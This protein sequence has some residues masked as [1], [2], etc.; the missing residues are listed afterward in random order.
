M[1]GDVVMDGIAV[2]Q[3]EVAAKPEKPAGKRRIGLIVAIVVAIVAIGALRT[4][5]CGRAVSIRS[6][7]SWAHIS[8]HLDR[9]QAAAK[10]PGAKSQT[11]AQQPSKSSELAAVATP[12]W[13]AKHHVRGAADLA[14]GHHGDD[15]QRGRQLRLLRTGTTPRTAC[16]FPFKAT[17]TDG[18]TKNGTIS[19]L[20]VDGAWFFA[21]LD[22]GVTK[23]VPDTQSTSRSST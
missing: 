23:E 1:Q 18:T 19:L 11:P 5:S 20:S 14:G 21:G 2:P 10:A 8:A 3:V 6:P 13:A 16:R 17:L 4:R 7:R 15:R 9:A 22:T 12:A